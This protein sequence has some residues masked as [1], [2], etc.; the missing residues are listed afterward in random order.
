M[1]INNNL[2]QYRKNAG[3]KQVHIAKKARIS[4]RNYQRIE[5]GKQ[6]P[7]VSVAILIAKALHTTVEELFPLQTSANAGEDKPDDS[8]ENK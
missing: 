8:Q 1:K 6:E 4:V 2:K 5:S 3:L 7:K